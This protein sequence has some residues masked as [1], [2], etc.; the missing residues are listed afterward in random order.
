M[1]AAYVRVGSRHENETSNGISH[2][3][4]HMLFRGS[5]R[6]PDS[7]KM[8]A[9]VEAVG[10]N[11]NGVTMRD[12]SYYY[13][14]CH[15][16]GV[17]VAIN[18]L[19]D[20]LTSPRLVHLELEKQIIL[21]E[22]LDEVD[23][24][25]RDID[26]DNLSKQVLYHRHPLS[27]KIAGT[28]KSVQGLTRKMALRHFG[29]A[30]VAGNMVVAVAGPH[31][32]DRLFQQ[33]DRAFRHTPRGAR[34][35]EVAP[36]ATSRREAEL[37][38]VTHPEPQVEFRLSFPATSDS[39]PDHL[40]L[41]TL[42]RVLDDGL[43]SRLP[44]NVV[45]RRGLAYSVGAAIEV[46]HDTGTF[47]VEGACAPANVGDVLAEI[48]RTLATLRRGQISTAELKRAQQRT[49]IHLDF[50]HDS[51]GD[52]CSWFG[53]T[54]LFRTPESFE[55]RSMQVEQLRVRDLVA[56]ADRYLIHPTMV[57]TAVGPTSARKKIID[58]VE[59]HGER[60]LRPA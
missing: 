53:G 45:E 54:E 33:I 25:G 50:L 8:N 36:P 28:P 22:M 59:T 60:L 31:H 42:R 43:S 2:L 58:A 27:F 39:H 20:M 40:A 29:E 24:R 48:F 47:E 7:V 55:D 19:G 11:L 10:G 49:R 13:T 5:A 23:E 9:A 51:P 26:V 57:V 37:R 3:V 56:V 38:Y 14:P 12:S 17:P 34:A 52:L 4:E 16:D 15:P 44:H 21:E 32:H 41:A 30:Y 6:F 46:F 35:S 1:C 18:I